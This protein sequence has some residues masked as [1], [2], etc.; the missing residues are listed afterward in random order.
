L[1]FERLSHIILADEA[2]ANSPEK[3]RKF[4]KFLRSSRRNEPLG[5]Q[6]IGNFFRESKLFKLAFLLE[7]KVKFKNN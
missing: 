4:I 1:I 2:L 3:N 7:K 5:I 6:V